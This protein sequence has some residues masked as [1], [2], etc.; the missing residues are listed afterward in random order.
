MIKEIFCLN[1]I[2]L[3]FQ[4]LTLLSTNYY[5]YGNDKCKVIIVQVASLSKKNIQKF[6]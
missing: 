4:I 1:I 3:I 6:I 2:D 5:Y